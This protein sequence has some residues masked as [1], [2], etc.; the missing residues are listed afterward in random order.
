MS[1]EGLTQLAARASA[2]D[3]RAWH[4]LWQLLEPRIW[5]MSGRW[6]LAGPLCQS[7][8]D[9]REIV[10]RVM[11]KLR[12]AG[13]RR[14]RAFAES[15]GATSDAAF[16]AWL[17]AV[18][19]RVAIDAQRAHPEHVG[20]TDRARWV[21]LVPLDDAPPP[22]TERDLTAHAT[23]LRVLEHARN[24]LTADQLTALSMWLEGESNDA[25]ARRLNATTPQDAQRTLRAALKR[26]RDRFRDSVP[27]QTVED[28]S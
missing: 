16:V 6:Q 24:E 9:R 1:A 22:L 13:F 23:V 3:R 10:L 11:A 21:D 28:P 5:A 26:L 15:A 7:A 25:I 17:T 19:T 20:R 14:L 12:H 8:D 18:T 4:A 2:G 27:A